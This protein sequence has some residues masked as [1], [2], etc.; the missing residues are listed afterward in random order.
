[1]LAISMPCHMCFIVTLVSPAER[2]ILV[3]VA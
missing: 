3:V 2:Y 1:M